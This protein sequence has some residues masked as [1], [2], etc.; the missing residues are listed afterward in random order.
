MGVFQQPF[1]MKN[2]YLTPNCHGKFE[3]I[4]DLDGKYENIAN[5]DFKLI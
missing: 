5:L 1:S 2:S 3:N 4:A